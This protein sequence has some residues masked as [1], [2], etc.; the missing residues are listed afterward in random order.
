MEQETGMVV[1]AADWEDN[2]LVLA[3]VG[4]E[5]EAF[6]VG[7]KNRDWA[8]DTC[9]VAHILLVEVV[10]ILLVAVVAGIEGIHCIQA[11]SEAEK[12]NHD[13][14]CSGTPFMFPVM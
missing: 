1:V 8:G 7:D 14:D 12:N 10:G 4:A 13:T 5:G 11:G 6:E 9:L 2:S 3:G